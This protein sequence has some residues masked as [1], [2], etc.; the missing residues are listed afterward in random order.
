MRPFLSSPVVPTFSEVLRRREFRAMWFA[1]LLSQI[2]DQFARVALAVLVFE[3]THSAALTALTY[4]LTLVPQLVG[5]ILFAGLG[6]RHPRRELMIVADLARAV[7]IGLAA[8]PHTPLAIL[9]VLVAT[10]TLL[11]G[12]FKAAQQALLP[13]V[14]PGDEYSVGMA[15]RQMTIQAGQLAGFATGGLLVAAV[16]PML[17]LLLDA[18][19]FVA[20]AV[21]VQTGVGHYP[22][23]AVTTG[24]PSFV[25]STVE[26]SRLVWYDP[27]L[28]TLLLLAWLSTF[29]IASEAIAAPYAASIGGGPI[30][31]GLILASVPLGSVLGGVV[32][33]RWV[34]PS[35]QRP[36]LGLMAVVAGVPL[37]F[38]AVSP[39]LVVSLCLFAINGVFVTGYNI[40]AATT[41]IRRLPDAMRA[42]GSGLATTSLSTVQGLGALVA[43]VVAD[44]AGPPHTIAILGAIGVACSIGLWVAW[45]RASAGPDTEPALPERSGSSTS[46][47]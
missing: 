29:Y 8:I 2:G 40:Q 17:G 30:W 23:A 37:L 38:C 5:G 15:L 4:A 22:A 44:H 9:C 18:A 45:T 12:P 10:M 1:E 24:R 32:F 36:R 21:V 6:D 28:R 25:R 14:L 43:G 34:P 20:S 46:P 39:P 27:R 35:W 7:L 47:T 11:A 19:T 33:G 3:R 41:F 31:V 16:S 42:Q 26:G 13:D